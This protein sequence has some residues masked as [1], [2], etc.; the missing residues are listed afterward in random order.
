M[1]T[2]DQGFISK[3]IFLGHKSKEVNPKENYQISMSRRCDA[4][5]E[6]LPEQEQSQGD[7]WWDG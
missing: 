7:T 5:L 1:T 4:M 2:M 3:E 6:V